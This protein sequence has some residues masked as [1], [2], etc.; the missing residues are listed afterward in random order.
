MKLLAAT[1]LIVTGIAHAATHA[2]CGAVA[3]GKGLMLVREGKIDRMCGFIQATHSGPHRF[4]ATAKGT[5]LWLGKA[6]VSGPVTL[7][8]GTFYAVVIEAPVSEDF[9]LK[10]DQPL[11]IPMDIPATALYQPTETVKPGCESLG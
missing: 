3:P 8:A 11:G 10:W 5:R 6:L 1:L 4:T 2:W 7:K 9:R